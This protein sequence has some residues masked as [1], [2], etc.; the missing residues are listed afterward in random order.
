MTNALHRLDDVDILREVIL[1]A[2]PRN[3]AS[4][5]RHVARLQ[6]TVFGL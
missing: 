4:F 3:I 5:A 6:Y 1:E 2:D